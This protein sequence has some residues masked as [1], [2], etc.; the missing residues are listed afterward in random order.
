MS[1]LLHPCSC[2]ASLPLLA[3]RCPAVGPTPLAAAPRAARSTVP[4]LLLL[5]LLLLLLY[6]YINSFLGSHGQRWVCPVQ[7]VM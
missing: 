2:L 7:E 3:V 4:A 1:E 6:L 5:L